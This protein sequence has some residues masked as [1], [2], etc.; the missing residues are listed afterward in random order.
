[1][2]THTLDSESSDSEPEISN[3]SITRFGKKHN[4]RRSQKHRRELLKRIL[5]LKYVKL[6]KNLLFGTDI[7]EEPTAEEMV[8]EYQTAKYFFNNYHEFFI[9]NKIHHF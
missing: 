4:V 7:E 2:F 6:G 3:V 1:M 9:R 5:F 8:D